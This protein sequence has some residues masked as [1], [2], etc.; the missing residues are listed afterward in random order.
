MRADFEIV[1][2]RTELPPG[3]AKLSA[4]AAAEGV[5][6]V[7]LLTAAWTD[8]TERFEHDGAALYGAF[9]SAVLL[10]V[11]GVTR[12]AG[13]QE[14][15][16]RMRRF[17]IL[18]EWRRLGV[19][20]ALAVAAMKRGL[21]DAGLLTCNAKATPLAAPFWEALGFRRVDRAGFTH[22]YRA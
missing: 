7:G 19:G 8:K 9:S 12:E 20:R 6:N 16:M 10:G 13:L 15:A 17:Y 22:L 4:A 5:R 11:G 2:I 1:R 14:P 3:M 21:E 18:P